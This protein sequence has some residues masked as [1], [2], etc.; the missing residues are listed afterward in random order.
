MCVCV[1]LRLQCFCSEA[2]VYTS[3]KANKWTSTTKG[4]EVLDQAFSQVWFGLAGRVCACITLCN[5]ATPCAIL[6]V[7]LRR[8]PASRCASAHA[9]VWRLPRFS[10]TARVYSS[11]PSPT[12]VSVPHLHH[13]HV[14]SVIVP[15]S[16]HIRVASN[17]TPT[18]D[19][20]LHS[21]R[22]S[23]LPLWYIAILHSLRAPVLPLWYIVP[24]TVALTVC[25]PLCP[26]SCVCA[27]ACLR[28]CVSACLHVR[29]VPSRWSSAAVLLHRLEWPFCRPV[30]CTNRTQV[31]VR[32]YCVQAH[33]CALTYITRSTGSSGSS[34]F[35]CVD[36][37]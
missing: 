13:T 32:Q 7:L 11:C 23:V 35:N 10:A 31:R 14:A 25:V 2:N 17:F 15:H 12:L 29:A 28:V 37:F 30:M 9:H 21:L 3:I 18:P 34:C 1:H 19:A 33:A 8:R 27:S 5:L 6:P 26:C 24:W 16:H 4:T 22:A 20:I 36:W